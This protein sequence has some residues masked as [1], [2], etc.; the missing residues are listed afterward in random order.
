M[1]YNIIMGL[2]KKILIALIL[3]FILTT[4]SYGIELNNSIPSITLAQK[5]SPFET[6][7]I[8]EEYLED[9]IEEESK[10]KET[11]RERFHDVFTHQINDHEHVEYLFDEMT[12]K[13]FKNGPLDNIEIWGLWR[14]ALTETI[15]SNG[16]D[17]TRPTYNILETRLH[18]TF[19]NKKTSFVI[20]TRY[21]PQHEF[22]FMQNLFSDTFIRHR[23][24]KQ[25]V[26]TIGNTR[27]HTGEEGAWSEL[28][29]PFFNRSQIS[30]HFGNIRKLGV[31]LSGEYKYLDY[32]VAI[33]SSGTYFR[34][35]FPGAEVCSWV[36][37]KPLANTNGK[38]GDLKI[39]AGIT[40]GRR[41][42]NYNNIGAYIGYKYKKFKADFEVANGDGYNGR[43]GAANIHAKGYYTTLYYDL[44][45]KIQLV[46]RF[47]DFIP[48]CHNSS[49]HTRE[50]SAGINYF[51]KGQALK[52]MLNYVFREDNMTGNT[53]Q[54]IIGT[55]ILL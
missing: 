46:A 36:N 43:L 11:L 39:G 19:R 21:Y 27:T 28:L 14:G 41:H 24:N 34:E 2:R 8:K 4:T 42:F 40:A 31:R 15:F 16:H 13:H 5:E 52:L 48:N 38:Y 25:A 45:D 30:K 9:D 20:T 23:F 50:Y 6:E 22:T 53:N 33:N 3:I 47:D 12:T 18:G 51:I 54:I 17:D 26:L 29:I 1:I 7:I 10:P 49:H 32:D 37:F 35:F 55:Q 44:T